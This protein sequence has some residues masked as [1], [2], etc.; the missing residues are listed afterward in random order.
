MTSL[1]GARK[2][3]KGSN[4]VRTE[5]I[6]LLQRRMFRKP[7]GRGGRG[8]LHAFSSVRQWICVSCRARATICCVVRSMMTFCLPLATSFFKWS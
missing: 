5:T 6:S 4:P 7:K 8:V 2:S 3:S 1:L